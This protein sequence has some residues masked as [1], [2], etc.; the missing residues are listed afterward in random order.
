MF[1]RITTV[2]AAAA[3]AVVMMP[4]ASEAGSDKAREAHTGCALTKMFDRA[5]RRTERAT[6]TVVSHDRTVR[7][8]TRKR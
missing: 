8:S 5:A 4:A 2:A 6:R 1:M 3:F 7:V